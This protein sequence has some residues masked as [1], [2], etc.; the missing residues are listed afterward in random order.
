ML[1]QQKNEDSDV[2]IISLTEI[3]LD[4]DFPAKGQFPWLHGI[5][6]H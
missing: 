5:V 4:I 1:L 3:A 6:H 2:V